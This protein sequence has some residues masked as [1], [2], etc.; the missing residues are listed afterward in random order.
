MTYKSVP[1]SALLIERSLFSGMLSDAIYLQ[2]STA[3]ADIEAAYANAR[4]RKHLTVRLDAIDAEL[5][6]RD[7]M[8]PPFAT[9]AD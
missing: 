3:P 2:R 5:A 9:A 8:M 7:R 1:T 4:L 6:I